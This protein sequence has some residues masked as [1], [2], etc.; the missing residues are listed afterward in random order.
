[1][2]KK[3]FIIA[4]ILIMIIGI[5]AAIPTVISHWGGEETSGDKPQEKESAMRQDDESDKVQENETKDSDHGR[6]WYDD[7]LNG[8]VLSR[9]IRFDEK[10]YQLTYKHTDN[11][12][13]APV[14][15]RSDSFG[16]YDVYTD[17]TKAEFSFLYNTD[18]LVGANMFKNYCDPGPENEWIDEKEAIAV[19]DSFIKNH[20]ENFSEYQMDYFKYSECEGIYTITYFRPLNGYKTNDKISLWIAVN[21]EIER[22]FF[23]N[24]NRYAD[25][26]ISESA[27]KEAQDK[28]ISRLDE[29]FGKDKYTV[30]GYCLTKD[31]EGYMELLV[32]VEYYF[33]GTERAGDVLSQRIN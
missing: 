17:G 30:I 15:K 1:M 29:K 33:F 3:I 12:K 16:T 10:Q 21:G 27:Y 25:A 23:H 14:G 18:L 8:K 19:A 31:D 7:S 6:G 4:V 26:K 24:L 20:L 32:N 13:D 22:F 11:W 2:K 5:S 9:S 28:L